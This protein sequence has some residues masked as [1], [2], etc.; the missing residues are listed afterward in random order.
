VSCATW[1]AVI[2]VNATCTSPI[3]WV[4]A[5]EHYLPRGGE[6]VDESPPAVN[7]RKDWLAADPVLYPVSLALTTW[8]PAAGCSASQLSPER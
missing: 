3:P 1:I 4:G 2:F 6:R 8:F 7:V 5:R